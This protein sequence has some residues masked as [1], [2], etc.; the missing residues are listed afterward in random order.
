[1]KDEILSLYSYNRWANE[2]VLTALRPLA[3]EDYTKE[4][5]G[6]WPS[7]RATLVHLAGASDAWATRFSGEDATRLPTVEELPNFS[8][9]E[10]LL[11]KSQDH[12]ER[13]VSGFSPER[14]A[15]PFVWK[16]LRLEEKRAPLWTVVR[17]VVNHGSYH[18]GQIASM[19]RRV[20]GHP[21]Q[22]DMILWGIELLQSE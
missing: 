19:L 8:D 12:L 9:G 11:R 6:G 4:L 5:G 21:L 10:A 18:R 15:A 2:R 13:L 22:T 20:G 1:M 14:L 3:H 7:L 16:N 17:H